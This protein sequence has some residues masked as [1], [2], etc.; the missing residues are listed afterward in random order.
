MSLFAPAAKVPCPDKL[1]FK[2]EEEAI[3]ARAAAK[4][5]HGNQDLAVY[6]CEKCDFWHLA[7]KRIEDD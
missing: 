6:K 3:A 4:H 2:S 1:L 7:T 5:K